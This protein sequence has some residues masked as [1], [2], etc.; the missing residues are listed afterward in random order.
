MTLELDAAALPTLATNCVLVGHAQKADVVWTR[1]DFMAL[2]EHMM[3]ENERNF[4]LIPYRKEDGTAHFAKAKKARADRRA[5]WAWDTIS[6]RAKNPAS[7]GFYPGNAEGKSRW[8]ALD[9]DAHGDNGERARELALAA[10]QILYRHPQLF[11]V[12]ATS[13]SGGWHLFVFTRDSHPVEDWNRLLKQVVAMI[14]ANIRKGECEIFPSDSHGRVGYGIRAPGT[15]NPKYDSFSLIA[16]EN[17]SPFLRAHNEERKRVS[18]SSRSNNGLER[19]D[20]T[21]RNEEVLYRGEFDEWQTRFAITTPRTRR[22][23]LK[24]MVEHIFRQVGREVAR[25]NAEFQYNEKT[26]ATEA[27]LSEHLQEFDELWDW[28]E[29]RWLTELS[30][31]ERKK[32][33]ALPMDSNDRAAFPI[34]RNFARLVSDREGDFKIVAEHLAK[35]LGVTL[36]T[37]CNIR[38]RFCNAGILIQTAA[39]VPQ[40]FAARFRWTAHFQAKQGPINDFKYLTLARSL[41]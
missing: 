23:R 15:W 6:G 24:A 28:W 40:R 13:G 12:L 7:I 3:N 1:D 10:F 22:E 31:S 34:I 27:T 33:E 37:A 39:C 4:F 25:R 19:A 18:L 29:T 5:S 8:G 26:V 38:R 14:G 21:Y 9:F 41:G 30:D 36:Q 2:C 32:F 17:I 16:F 20:L 35:R 11:V